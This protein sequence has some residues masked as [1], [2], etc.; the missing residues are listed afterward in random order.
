MSIRQFDLDWYYVL[1]SLWRS[2]FGLQVAEKTNCLHI[3]QG[4]A[5]N[6]ASLCL[7]DF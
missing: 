3:N 7:D 6:A 1:K 5:F 4:V 2:N